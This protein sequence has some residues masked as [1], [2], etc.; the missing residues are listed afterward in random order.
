MGVKRRAKKIARHQMNGQSLHRSIGKRTDA[1]YD[2]LFNK[3]PESSSS[4]SRV[5]E[6][7]D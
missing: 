3:M 2:I 5:D 7:F 4:I 6:I 1:I